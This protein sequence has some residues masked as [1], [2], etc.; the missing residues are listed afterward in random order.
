MASCGIGLPKE[1]R[2]AVKNAVKQ[3]QAKLHQDVVKLSKLV[4]KLMKKQSEKIPTATPC[5]TPVYF[6][7][8]DATKGA[9]KNNLPKAF[10]ETTHES[11]HSWS[12]SQHT[13]DEEGI[14]HYSGS[15]SS[16]K[17]QDTPS[18]AYHMLPSG[19]YSFDIKA[20]A[21]ETRN[22]LADIEVDDTGN[23][24]GDANP[25]DSESIPDPDTY[26]EAT[27]DDARLYYEITDEI[28]MKLLMTMPSHE[29]D[30]FC[31]ENVVEDDREAC[32]EL[33][34]M[35]EALPVAEL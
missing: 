25:N 29:I 28:V 1:T 26:S 23:G 19:R 4:D 11:V 22:S 17:I 5:T 7:E 21:R 10:E 9:Q 27:N 18:M 31:S 32:R 34:K 8:T 16:L 20:V 33:E 3:A 35:F 2:K 15:Q 14:E 30:A 12:R 24:S 13:D 6:P